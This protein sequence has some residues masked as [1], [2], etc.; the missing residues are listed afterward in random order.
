VNGI[1]HFIDEV[2]SK[3][4]G[5]A[6]NPTTDLIRAQTYMHATGILCCKASRALF[7]LFSKTTMKL[8]TH[9]LIFSLV[10]EN[11]RPQ[12]ISSEACSSEEARA[13][14]WPCR[15]LPFYAWMIWSAI[16]FLLLLYFLVL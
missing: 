1:M 7:I 15:K 12:E 13:E 14:V 6:G 5:Q 8:R 10:Q 2:R 16:P 4:T 9:V 3:M 11:N